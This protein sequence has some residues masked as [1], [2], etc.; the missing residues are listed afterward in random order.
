MIMDNPEK[1]NDARMRR[2]G[3]S[4]KDKSI[5]LQLR[6]QKDLSVRSEKNVATYRKTRA[7]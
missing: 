4:A 3:V 7:P 2:M 6:K 5:M 1:Q